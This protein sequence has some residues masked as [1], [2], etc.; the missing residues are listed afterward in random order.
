MKTFAQALCESVGCAPED[1]LRVALKHCLYPRPRSFYRLFAPFVSAADLQLLKDA[2]AATTEDQLNEL[3]R[4]Y[5]Y[6]LQLNGGFLRKRLKLR[7][8]TAHLEHLFK[9]MLRAH[10][11][12]PED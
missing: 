10:T 4:E 12:P 8:S 2:G 6:D 9:Q 5:R 7:V 3:L 11:G 1:Y